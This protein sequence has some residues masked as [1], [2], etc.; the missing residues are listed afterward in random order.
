M[1]VGHEEKHTADALTLFYKTM[2]ISDV[3]VHIK[4]HSFGILLVLTILMYLAE[5]LT[6]N[7]I[8]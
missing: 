4:L 8:T 1:Q 5:S 3:V 7:G 2:F 6:V